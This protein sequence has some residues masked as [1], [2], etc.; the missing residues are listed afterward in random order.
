MSY[1][2]LKIIAYIKYMSYICANKMKQWYG[3]EKEW[4]KELDRKDEV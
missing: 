2:S 1:F 4:V 3:K